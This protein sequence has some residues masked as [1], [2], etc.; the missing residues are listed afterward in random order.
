MQPFLITDTRLLDNLE[1]L[2]EAKDPQGKA[3]MR[4]RGVFQR[5][6]EVNNNKRRYSKK[7]ME[8]EV[9]NLQEMISNSQLCGELDHPTY[10]IVKLSNASHQI[11]ALYMEG[12]DVI[13]EAKILST[14]AGQVAQALIKDGVKIGISSRGLGTLS[15]GKDGIA[16]VNNDFKMVTFDLVADPSTRGAFPGL[17]ESKKTRQ[18]IESTMKT[19]YGNKIFIEVLRRE[20]DKELHESKLSSGERDAARANKLIKRA[21]MSD[22]DSTKKRAVKSAH[23]NLDTA[24]NRRNSAKKFPKDSIE[25]ENRIRRAKGDIRLSKSSSNVAKAFG[26][27]LPESTLVSRLA[28]LLKEGYLAGKIMKKAGMADLEKAGK[29]RRAA[30]KAAKGSTARELGKA[31]AKHYLAQSKEKDK[32][33][34]SASTIRQVWNDD[35]VDESFSRKLAKSYKK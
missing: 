11:T 25:R 13:G 17:T 15:E 6:D 16:E 19:A 8:R 2:S 5:A 28:A 27:K 7:I 14:P 31:S 33:A 3:T 34:K 18:L 24:A 29:A 30:T 10:D 32:T 4:V 26:H 35:D 21:G 12:N 23:L 9:K 1:I 22:G 20:I